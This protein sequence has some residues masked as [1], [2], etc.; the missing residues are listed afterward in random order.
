MVEDDT[1]RLES[2]E[3]VPGAESVE[4]PADLEEALSWHG[5]KL[6]EMGGANVG[7]VAGVLVDG[8]DGAP[9][10]L[11]AR[12]GRFGRHCAV[13]FELVAPGVGHVWVPYPRATI[14]AASEIDPSGGLSCADETALAAHYGIPDGTGR[15]GAIASRD[16]DE[17]SSVPAG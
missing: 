4:A 17:R 2:A 10:W 11:I 15:L 12:L 16:G 6:D 13:P 9:T 14:R 1:P 8:E 5:A 7:R 3:D